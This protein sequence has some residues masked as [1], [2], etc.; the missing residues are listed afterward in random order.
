M[1]D[2]AWI[3]LAVIVVAV[4]VLIVVLTTRQMKKFRLSFPVPFLKEPFVLSRHDSE[5]VH[6]ENLMRCSVQ[7]FETFLKLTKRGDGIDQDAVQG[8]DAQVLR[9]LTN[10]NLLHADGERLDPA[11]IRLG[12]LGWQ[13]LQHYLRQNKLGDNP[14]MEPWNWPQDFPR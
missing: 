6:R 13:A 7:L 8:T 11:S 9:T 5:A 4:C 14:R 10:L 1:S 12:Y 2:T 3:S